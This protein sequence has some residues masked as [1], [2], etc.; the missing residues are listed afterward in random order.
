VFK[1]QAKRFDF[2]YNQVSGI[3]KISGTFTCKGVMMYRI[4]LGCA[5]YAWMNLIPHQTTVCL[6]GARGDFSSGTHEVRRSE[7]NAKFFQYTIMDHWFS[8]NHSIFLYHC[9]I[10]HSGR[11]CVVQFAKRRADPTGKAHQSTDPDGISR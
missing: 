4:R 9:V 3:V 10:N 7:E 8:N 1:S 6:G 11:L 2:M 5:V